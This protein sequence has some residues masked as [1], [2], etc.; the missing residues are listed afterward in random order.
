VSVRHRLSIAAAVASSAVVVVA[1]GPKDEITPVAPGDP[2]I[3]AATEQARATLPM[4][5][6]KY[7]SQEPGVDHFRIK[8][9]MRTPHGGV[10]HI[11]VDVVSHSKLAAKGT[12]ANDPDDLGDLKF[13]SAVVVDEA[14]ITDWSYDRGGKTYGGYSIRVFANRDGVEG[15]RKTLALLSPTPLET[16]VH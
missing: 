4:F 16:D 11:W 12:L 5:W 10:E 15:R 9:P 2:Q 6:S 7:D 1:C 13:G 3:A 14:N 8:T